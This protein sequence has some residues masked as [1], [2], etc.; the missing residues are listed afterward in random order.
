VDFGALTKRATDRLAQIQRVGEALK[1]I[2]AELRQQ[3][4]RAN[5]LSQLSVYRD[6]KELDWRSLTVEIDRLAEERRELE[7]ASDV[8][9]ALQG[10]LTAVEQ[11]IETLEASFSD[12]QKKL[13]TTD[14][15]HAERT[16]NRCG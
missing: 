7:A 13:A 1:S 15:K 16:R 14:T 4:E 8:L 10:R 12:A 6:F 11:D 3:R 9:R 2:N 5:W